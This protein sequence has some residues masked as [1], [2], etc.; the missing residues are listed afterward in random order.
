MDEDE[1][2]HLQE[3][4]AKYVN[5]LRQL[6]LQEADHG[7]NAPLNIVNG[8]AKHEKL[9]A[10]VDTKLQTIRQGSHTL[11]QIDLAKLLQHIENDF[12]NIKGELIHSENGFTSYKSLFSFENSRNNSVWCSGETRWYFRC[13]FYQGSDLE[14]AESTYKEKIYRIREVLE[15][16]WDF[17]EEEI[18]K[19]TNSRSIEVF[20]KYNTAKLR[21]TLSQTDNKWAVYFHIER[22]T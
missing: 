12:Q 6:R 11:F 4:R 19:I 15:N 17:D 1:I 22:L 3:L 21:I 13:K 7:L 20:K 5:N 16:E 14:R 9:I 18:D 2:K 10:E 8:I